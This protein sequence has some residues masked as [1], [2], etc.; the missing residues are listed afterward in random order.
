ML[1]ITT[2]IPTYRRPN[3][4]ARCLDALKRQN[5]CADEVLIVV[6]DTDIDTWS[7]LND[8]NAK[9]L[10]LK[11]LTV[12]VPGVVAA[13]NLGLEAARGEVIA[14]TDDDAAPHPDWLDRIEKHFYS[15]DCLGGLGGRD[16]I[17]FNGPQKE[18]VQAPDKVRTIGQVQWFGRM[19]GNHHLGQGSPRKVDILKGVNMSFR[20]AALANLRC[21]ERLKGSG[22]QVH[23]EVALSLSVKQRGWELLYD[24]AVAV[25]HFQAQRFDEDQRTTFNAVACSN[26]AHN[27]TLVLLDHFHPGQRVVYLIWAILIGTRGT[28]GLLQLLRLLP[29][30]GLVAVQMWQAAMQGRWHGW[31]TWRQDNSTV[32]S[33]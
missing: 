18:W 12:Y 30:D 29:R 26:I 17:Q 32:M 19:V 15:D 16:Y 21:D 2:L 31:Q 8:Y 4:L 27:E 5:R 6:R 13:L 20:R 11:T 33:V 10:P 14:I 1:T 7:F 3:D 24:P 9:P 28:P 22:A 25:D 23:F